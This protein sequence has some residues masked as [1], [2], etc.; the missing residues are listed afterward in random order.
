VIRHWRS[1]LNNLNQILWLNAET[2]CN[3]Y[4]LLTN[5]LVNSIQNSYGVLGKIEVVKE[6]CESIENEN[7]S[8]FNSEFWNVGEHLNKILEDESTSKDNYGRWTRNYSLIALCGVIE[9]HL[10]SYFPLVD[11][12]KKN[13]LKTEYL[14][15]DITYLNKLNACYTMMSKMLSYE[16]LGADYR[17][18]IEAKILNL[19]YKLEKH[20]KKVALRPTPCLY[21]SMEKDVNHF[22]NSCCHPKQLLKLVNDAQNLLHTQID[23]GDIKSNKSAASFKIDIAD[24]IGKMNLWIINSDKFMGH[25][26]PKYSAYYNDFTAPV[27]HGIVKIKNGFLGLRCL[28]QM[29]HDSILLKTSGIYWNC[30]ENDQLLIVMKNLIKFPA[31]HEISFN[32]KINVFSFIECLENSEAFEMKMLKAS[33]QENLNTAAI[34]SGNMTN[35]EFG[36]FDHVLNIFNQ[37]WQ[38]QEENKRKRQL[39]EDSLYV[40]KTKCAEEDEEIVKLREISQFFPD[41]SNEDFS[42]FLQSN[43]L[44]QVVKD[45]SKTKKLADVIQ[46]EEYKLI[47]NFFI[48]LMSE[49]HQCKEKN[50]FKVFDNKLNVFNGLL[51]KFKTVIDNTFDDSSYNSLC[52]LV[53]LCLIKFDDNLQSKGKSNVLYSI[54]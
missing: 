4:D 29:K 32:S 35:D 16:E 12:V 30:N 26:L 8:D 42:D 53:G 54:K 22:L 24:L 14:R 1:T 7:Y 27:E 36:K 28:L 50:Y 51:N 39:E 37:L 46:D 10:T 25:T 40:T 38:K 34:T 33:I 2:C 6:L 48:T 3:K 20:S 11:P 19:E 52:M 5:S 43:T 23:F 21:S 45:E 31:S 44:D 41:H 15:E 49:T 18:A 9:L 17:R 13:K 47:G